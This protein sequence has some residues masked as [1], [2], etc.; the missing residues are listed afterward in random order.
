MLASLVEHKI[1][2]DGLNLT[3][4]RDGKILSLTANT[5]PWPSLIPYIR[6]AT[7]SSNPE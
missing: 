4:Y 3:I 6:Q 2:G 1:P 5:K 7:S